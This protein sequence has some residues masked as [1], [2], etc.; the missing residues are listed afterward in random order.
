MNIREAW[1]RRTD[2]RKKGKAFVLVLALGLTCATPVA[3]DAISDA[4]KKKADAQEEL[5]KINS[6]IAG[7]QAAQNSLQSEMAGYD[8]Q[9]MAVLTD[10]EILQGDMDT[11]E[12]EIEQANAD[13]ENAR[14]EEE[15]QYEAMK[16]R[17]RYMYENGD[18]SVWTALAGADGM[19]D[20]LNRAEYITDV[21]EYDRQLLT[22][23]QD[24]VRQVEDLTVQLANEMAEMEEMELYYQEQQASLEQMIAT[25]QAQIS[26]FDSQLAN[27]QVLAQ[28]YAKTIRQQNQ[29]IAKEKAAQQAANANKN[30]GTA[31]QKPGGG[32]NAGTGGSSG[33]SST[34]LTDGNLN[35]GYAT[36]VS[37]SQVVDYA[38][39]FLGCPYVLGGTSL[40]NGTDC[41][42]F[43]MAVYQNFGISIP[44]TSYGQRTCGQAVSYENAQPGDLICYAG[45]VAIY[46][47]NGRIIHA[48]NPRTGVCY[49]NATYRTIVA[50]RRVL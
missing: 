43:T 42:Y 11:Q 38:S 9:L 37:G 20:F 24:V 1:N 29:I 7:I 12:V 47:G 48:S 8:E 10:M 36:G 26:D 15:Q 16:V 6:E 31:G 39:K 44:R 23:Y 19:S 40:T 30:N 25:M 18:R 28:Q 41:S 13:L 14:L 49:G 3:A 33:G 34:G 22:D 50:V 5:D 17:I 35:P 27:A 21:Y 32:S 4:E 45:H 2:K 46:V